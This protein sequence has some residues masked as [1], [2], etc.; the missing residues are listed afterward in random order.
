MMGIC[1]LPSSL[2]EGRLLLMM[3]VPLARRKQLG[4]C[5]TG[6]RTGRLLAALAVR[7]D[8]RSVVDPMAGHGDLL[9]AAAE[10]ARNIR[11]NADELMGVE[12]EREAARLGKW[13]VE[14][15]VQEFGFKR[16]CFIHGDSFAATTWNDTRRFDLV[17]TNP[18]YVRYQSL[19]NGTRGN[20]VQLLSAEATRCAL[21]RLAVKLSPPEEQL[22]WQ[23][24]IRSY[25]GLAD[26]SLPSWL[27][28]GLLTAPSGV[29]ALVVPQTWLNR[30]YARIARYFFLRFF[31]P[32]A[33]VQEFGQRWFQDAL[34]PVSLVVGRRLSTEQAVTPLWDRSCECDS[35]PFAEIGPVAASAHSHVGNSFAGAYPEGEFAKWLERGTGLRAG[36]KV[37]RVSWK[38][39]RDEVLAVS[40]GVKWLQQLEGERSTLVAVTSPST[41]P[42]SI[43]ARL[44]PSFLSNTRLLTSEPIRVG[45]GL[46]TGCNAFFYVELD[47]AT[48]NDDLV[49]VLTSD[50]FGRRRMTV[51]ISTLKPVLRRQ[52]EVLR[53]R[54]SSD[55]LRGRLLDL[56][57]FLLPEDMPR[58]GAA[59]RKRYRVMPEELAEYVRLAARTHFVRGETRTLIPDLSAVRPNGLGPSEISNSPAQPD[60]EVRR[61]WYMV[62]DF[63]PRHTASVCVPRIIHDEPSAVLNSDPP[64]LIDANFSTLWCENG[65]WTAEIIFAVLNST[66][67]ALCMEALGAILGGGAL[68]LEATH[69]RQFP[70]PILSDSAKRCLTSLARKTLNL[71]YDMASL[72]HHRLQIDQVVV[73]AL[74]QRRMSLGD[75]KAAVEK[76]AGLIHSLRAKRRR[77]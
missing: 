72:R 75:T 8:Q 63:A 16:G 73:S 39:Q 66:W 40:R 69:L 2:A 60:G 9:E 55:S 37:K 52:V 14:R 54:I 20:G 50:L 41:L 74:A 13:R 46:R 70:L 32:L 18:P 33:I 62:P 27:L 19:S 26:L 65:V 57:A 71:T 30:D 76:L 17:I 64:V 68:K 24:L 56:R 12:I 48:A 21:D 45:Q 6:L 38:C 47:G 1:S 28:C 36:V 10:R 42:A 7:H 43:A 51:P 22:I 58:N 25:S 29:L 44:Q 35:T 23:H 31:Q 77:S 5:F 4:Q 61:M 59:A 34:V 49:P 15:C 53:M 11:L 3:S 67:G